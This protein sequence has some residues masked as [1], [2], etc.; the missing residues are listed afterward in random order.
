M[1]TGNLKVYVVHQKRGMCMARPQ[2]VLFEQQ[3][4]RNI[5]L[6]SFGGSAQAYFIMMLA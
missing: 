6:G 2:A 4:L 3:G 1:G 5:V